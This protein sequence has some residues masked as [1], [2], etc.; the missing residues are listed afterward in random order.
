MTNTAEESGAARGA[1][2]WEITHQMPPPLLAWSRGQE[3]ENLP[4]GPTVRS[5]SSLC[6]RAC[7]VALSCSKDWIV[8]CSVLT[9]ALSPRTT[10]SYDEKHK[11]KQP[12]ILNYWN[13]SFQHYSTK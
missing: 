2:L 3:P 13:V 10:A 4:T 12:L 8:P 11:T 9:E 1:S 5:F 7:R 6:T